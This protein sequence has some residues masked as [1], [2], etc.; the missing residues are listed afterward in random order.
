MPENLAA[1]QRDCIL[2]A[3]PVATYGGYLSTRSAPE[4]HSA[5]VEPQQIAPSFVAVLEDGD[6]RPALVVTAFK[7]PWRVTVERLR[8]VSPFAGKVFQ[9]WA[10][11]RES[12]T[13]RPLLQVARFSR[14]PAT[15]FCSSAWAMKAGRP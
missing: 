7:G 15:T 8:D 14:S 1:E 5:T 4:P 2:L 3:L 11:E 6:N 9:I 10:V 13:I 12:G